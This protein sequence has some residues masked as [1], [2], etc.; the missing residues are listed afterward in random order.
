[1]KIITEKKD[2]IELKTKNGTKNMKKFMKN[3]LY[4]QQQRIA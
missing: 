1:M 4:N 2:K 3:H